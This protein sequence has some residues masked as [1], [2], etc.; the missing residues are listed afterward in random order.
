MSG[1]KL[2]YQ[3]WLDHL[4]LK[5]LSPWRPYIEVN[6]SFLQICNFKHNFE[7][8][9]G[10]IWLWLFYTFLLLVSKKFRQKNQAISI[11]IEGVAAIFS[12]FSIII[13]LQL[14][15]KT[16]SKNG[17]SQYVLIFCPKLPPHEWMYINPILILITKKLYTVKKWHEIQKK[18]QKIDC[19][20]FFY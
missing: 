3:T 14:I 15:E 19:C 13:G 5:P 2:I 18:L 17:L 12:N 16:V 8:S 4:L 7:V 1:T 6:K 10:K 11:K 9:R 20:Y